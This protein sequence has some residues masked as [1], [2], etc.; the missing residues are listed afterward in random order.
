MKS[1]FEYLTKKLAPKSFRERFNIRADLDLYRSATLLKYFKEHNMLTQS[2]D[3]S[4]IFEDICDEIE[5]LE[6]RRLRN[7]V[8]SSINSQVLI[9]F[10]SIRKLQS[11]Q[12]GRLI[13]LVGHEL[14][15][16]P[17]TV[18]GAG[19]GTFL[20]GHSAPG[21]VVAFFPGVVYLPEYIANAEIVQGLLPDPNHLLMSRST[22][23]SCFH[24]CLLTS[25]VEQMGA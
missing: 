3:K 22:S 11:A 4:K 18:K 8:N 2:I 16:L 5:K 15:L 13:D 7:F 21:K 19:S 25:F 10:E 24:L 12:S 17:S 14:C 23:E 1:A 20:K 9:I 6:S